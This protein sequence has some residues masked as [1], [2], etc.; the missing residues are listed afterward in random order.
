MPIN[1]LTISLYIFPQSKTYD[2]ISSPQVHIHGMI[3]DISFIYHPYRLINKILKFLSLLQAEE[4]DRRNIPFSF[5]SLMSV[6]RAN[7]VGQNEA[8]ILITGDTGDGDT[9]I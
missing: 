7:S 3:H 2:V 4:N 6:K 1:P 5:R 9:V 8:S